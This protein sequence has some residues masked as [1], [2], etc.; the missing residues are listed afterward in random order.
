MW[1]IAQG[2]FLGAAEVYRGT[3]PFPEICGR[4]CPQERLCEGACVLGRRDEAPS[5][6]KLEMFVAD[7]ARLVQGWP[8]AE[9]QPL[10]G[11]DVAVVGSG[12][13]GLAVAEALARRG[14]CVTVYEAAPHPGGLLL[15][16]I[17]NFKLPK[18]L[19]LG[20]IEALRRLGIAF[21]CNTRIGRNLTVDD[22]F[23]AG[24]DAVFLG[25]GA[26]AP[27]GAGR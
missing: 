18:E 19:V 3:S 10:S 17:P 13:A 14:H 2:D 9:R 20:K 15:Y 1:L 22:L 23:L 16:G 25:V 5:L 27:E 26:N 12:P 8:V 6:G 4:I 21:V 7:Y 24:F 11:K